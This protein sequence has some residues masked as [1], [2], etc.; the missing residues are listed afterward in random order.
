MFERCHRKCAVVTSF[1]YERN[2]NDLTGG[3][4]ESKLYLTEDG[5]LVTH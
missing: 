2:W 5:A 4:A 1:K 3:F